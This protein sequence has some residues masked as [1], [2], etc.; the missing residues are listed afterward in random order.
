M[1]DTQPEP[2]IPPPWS[3]LAALAGASASLALVIFVYGV[4]WL[5]HL[6]MSE[7]SSVTLANFSQ[8]LFFLGSDAMIYGAF[9]GY[10]GTRFRSLSIITCIT[11]I[12]M[13]FVA[14]MTSPRSSGH[15]SV[16]LGLAPFFAN[17]SIAS[18]VGRCAGGKIIDDRRVLQFS[19][20]EILYTFIPFA[21][22]FSCLTVLR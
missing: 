12:V 3:G 9:C 22:L 21:V 1:T 19:L 18:H 14:M 16:I 6:G 10:L 15:V 20:G 8:M 17:C 5:L 2:P 13:I 4:P 11:A 7:K